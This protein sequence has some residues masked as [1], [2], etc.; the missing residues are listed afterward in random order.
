MFNSLQHWLWLVCLF[1][2]ILILMWHNQTWAYV[3]SKVTLELAGFIILCWILLGLKLMGFEFI[4]SIRSLIVKLMRFGNA[5]LRKCED[6]RLKLIIW[7]ND[8]ILESSY[9]LLCQ[10]KIYVCSGECIRPGRGWIEHTRISFV[11]LTRIVQ[12]CIRKKKK[13]G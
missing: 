10:R 11:E 1:L 7:L 4:M 12:C 9:E 5:C 13:T 8:S 2:S 3:N 6:A